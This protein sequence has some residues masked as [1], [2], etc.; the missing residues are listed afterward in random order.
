[1]KN[2]EIEREFV[3]NNILNHNKNEDYVE[4]P[5][6][7][8]IIEENNQP[9]NE[10]VIE[11][12]EEEMKR[13]IEQ[14]NKL[15]LLNKNTELQHR[16]EELNLENKDLKE[17]LSKA[18]QELYN[19]KYNSLFQ[20]TNEMEKIEDENERLKNDYNNL[21]ERYEKINTQ[22]IITQKQIESVQKSQAIV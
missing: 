14:A 12:D 17:K 10:I 16:N 15:E 1:M 3:K 7:A 8:E 11:I 9:D 22:N 21:K 5:I 20:N 18:N 19:Y 2:H 13:N 6:K 4:I